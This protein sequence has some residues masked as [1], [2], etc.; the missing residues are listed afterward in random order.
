MAFSQ[1]SSGH[2]ISPSRFAR[3]KYSSNITNIL[4]PSV[5]KAPNDIN[6]QELDATAKK[7]LKGKPTAG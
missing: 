3:R 5:V 4:D 1:A 6:V 7:M 2:Y